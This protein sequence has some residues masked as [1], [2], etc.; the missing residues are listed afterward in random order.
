MR[1]KWK[2]FSHPLSAWEELWRMW[3]IRKLNCHEIFS[4]FVFFLLHFSLLRIYISR[5]LRDF[6]STSTEIIEIRFSLYQ[7]GLFNTWFFQVV[8]SQV[9]NLRHTNS[10]ILF[11]LFIFFILFHRE[12]ANMICRLRTRSVWRIKTEMTIR[13]WN[14]CSQILS[15][16]T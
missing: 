9:S 11:S 2:K 6:S 5:K 16:S 15:N 14:S 1:L 10:I 8:P 12:C 4:R 3:W 7:S 13:K